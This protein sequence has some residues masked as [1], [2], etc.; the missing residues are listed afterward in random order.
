MKGFFSFQLYL[1]EVLTLVNVTNTTR[2]YG[3]EKEKEMLVFVGDF[4]QYRFNVKMH[5][6]V[7]FT[8]ASQFY[9]QINVELY[10]HAFV[11]LY[12][13]EKQVC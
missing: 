12:G 9:V 13:G 3:D 11:Q 10:I 2:L 8:I 1:V 5:V 6:Q 7:R 4:F